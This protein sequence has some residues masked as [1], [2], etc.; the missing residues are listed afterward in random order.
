MFRRVFTFLALL[1]LEL[2][3]AHNRIVS[4]MPPIG[5]IRSRSEIAQAP[6]ARPLDNDR[7]M[8]GARAQA[9]LTDPMLNAVLDSLSARYRANFENSAYGDVEIRQVAY[10]QLAAL[11]D[12]RAALRGHLLNRAI[13]EADLQESIKRRK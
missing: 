3:A 8:N 5:D 4:G 6:S 10:Y 11:K 12:M 9:L 13:Y 1:W 2:K 7:T